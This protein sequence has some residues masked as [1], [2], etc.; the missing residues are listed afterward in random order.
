VIALGVFI[1]II[2]YH[3]SSF[4]KP[5]TSL[6]RQKMHIP[7]LVAGSVAFSLG[8]ASRS[9]LYV[10]NAPDH[11]RPYVIER[12]ANAQA[13]AVGQQIYRFPV[14]GA[15]SGGAFSILMPP[16]PW[17]F[18]LTFT[19]PITKTSF[20]AKVASSFG[21]T[22]LAMRRLES[23]YLAIMALYPGIPHIHSKS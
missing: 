6:L 12:Y 8:S 14:T 2:R 16:M 1:R 22:S 7:S 19:K 18:S 20:A 17:A 11:V 15:S 23:C 3:I 10:E 9:S 13:V 4:L 21:P 5:Y